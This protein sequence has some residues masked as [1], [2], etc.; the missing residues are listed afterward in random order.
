MARAARQTRRRTRKVAR[1]E[2]AIPTPQRLRR[3]AL[4]EFSQRG[5]GGTD[6][7]RIARRAGFAPQTFYRWYKDKTDIFIAVYQ[8]WVA[9]ELNAIGALDAAEAPVADLVETCII[10]HRNHRLFRRSLRQLALENP[11]VRGARAESRRH[12]IEMVRSW[13]PDNSLTAEEIAVALLE[14]ERLADAIAE[15][16][17]VD[18]KLGDGAGRKA[19]AAIILRLQQHRALR[20]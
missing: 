7:N 4:A 5:F 11:A 19:L 13:R 6:T 15:Q 1:G 18:M 17:F 16:E 2:G 9:E 8:E 10:H 14:I 20:R 3:A 12:Q